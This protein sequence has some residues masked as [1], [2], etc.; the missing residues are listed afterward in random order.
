[1]DTDQFSEANH[2]VNTKNE[3]TAA[4]QA[5]M[6]TNFAKFEHIKPETDL[7]GYRAFEDGLLGDVKAKR[8]TVSG[9]KNYS[10]K[11]F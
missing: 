4:V 7:S 9:L 1:M 3:L 11:M 5:A 10:K 6:K 8:N 2:P